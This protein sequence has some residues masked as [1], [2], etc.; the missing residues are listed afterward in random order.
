MDLHRRARRPAAG[1]IPPLIQWLLLCVLLAWASAAVADEGSRIESITLPS[2]IL[3]DKLLD[4]VSERHIKVYLPAGYGQGE[5]RYP[6][7]YYLH[8]FGWSPAQMFED[9]QVQQVLDR[10]IASHRVE[11]M[12]LVAGD[13]T[14][15]PYG[16]FYGNGPVS[17]RWEDHIVKE[18]V[19]A[20]DARYRTLP[21]AASRGIAGEMIGGYGAL[22]M[23]ML[24]PDIFASVYALHPV[25]TGRGDSLM[26]GKPDWA[27]MHA[28]RSIEDMDGDSYSQV[29]ARMAQEFLPDP[30]R[31]PLYIDFMLEEQDG[32]L[33][34]DSDHVTALVNAFLL[35]AM[36][37]SH[38]VQLRQL[39]GIAF[40][41]GRY[42][43][44]PDHV[45][46]NRRFTLLLDEYGID[47]R[48][49]EYRGN[50]YDQNWIA[51]GRVEND[52]LPFFASVL[53]YD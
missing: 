2:P 33:K 38:V 31:P 4:F 3:D 10:A 22:R 9:G 16:A 32:S 6:V 7:I 53:A 25:A 44:N 51:Q 14:G 12:I 8:S 50:H 29:F 46:S 45:Q 27:R 41:W 17:G 26:R 35:D 20:I 18:L 36:L 21:A 19:P 42:D 28:A 40:D 24:H 34:V 15:P 47:H 52:L 39:R 48:A 37:P 23:A 43:P 11:P 5:Q 30:Q 49:E 1:R 13:F